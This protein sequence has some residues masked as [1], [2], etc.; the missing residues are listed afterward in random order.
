MTI[1]FDESLTYYKEKKG[2][3]AF[4][5][6]NIKEVSA[7]VLIRK[8]DKM[9]SANGFRNWCLSMDDCELIPCPNHDILSNEC[10]MMKRGTENDKADYFY[11]PNN[12]IWFVQ[13]GPMHQRKIFQP[14]IDS[15]LRSLPEEQQGQQTIV[16]D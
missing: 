16:P 14:A 12:N 1:Y 5:A 11:F 8:V 10:V 9:M 6:W 2:K 3:L 4:Y 13:S 15:L 7:F